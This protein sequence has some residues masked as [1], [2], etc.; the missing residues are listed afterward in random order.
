MSTSRCAK[1]E[2]EMNYQA[3]TNGITAVHQACAV[4]PEETEEKQEKKRKNDK[5][6]DCQDFLTY[7]P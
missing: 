3:W 4:K 1:E 5:F 6:V 7:N 2:T